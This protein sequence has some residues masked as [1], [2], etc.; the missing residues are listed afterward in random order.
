[1]RPAATGV[2]SQTQCLGLNKSNRARLKKILAPYQDK[3][4]ID[5]SEWSR[6]KLWMGGEGTDYHT[7]GRRKRS[8]RLNEARILFRIRANDF[9]YYIQ[10][11]DDKGKD[12]SPQVLVRLHTSVADIV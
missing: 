4:H 2:M 10:G 12:V 7:P 6:F 3:L 9:F 1:M 11:G 5:Q 8:S